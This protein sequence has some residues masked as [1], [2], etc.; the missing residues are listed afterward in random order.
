MWY[1]SVAKREALFSMKKL[2]EIKRV[3][4]FHNWQT[5]LLWRE[6]GLVDD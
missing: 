3:R 2:R 5:G 4:A 6:N 1:P